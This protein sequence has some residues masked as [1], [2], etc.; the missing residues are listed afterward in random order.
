MRQEVREK[1]SSAALVQIR[2]RLCLF[3][4]TILNVLLLRPLLLLSRLSSRVELDSFA[5]VCSCALWLQLLVVVV[6]VVVIC[7]GSSRPRF[8]LPKQR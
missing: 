5:S 4:A 3:R 7:D 6:V 1:E 8:S 2:M